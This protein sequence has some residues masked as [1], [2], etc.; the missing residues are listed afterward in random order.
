M[1][2]DTLKIILIIIEILLIIIGIVGAVL[3]VL[4][5]TWVVYAAM[6]IQHFFHDG[7]EY[8]WAILVGFG[9]VTLV[10]QVLDYLI[11]IWG[12][13]KLG[14]GKYGQWGTIIGALVGAFAYPPFGIIIGP[15]VGALLGELLSGKKINA[16]LKAGTGAFLG[17]VTG[18]VMKVGLGVIMGIWIIVK[19]F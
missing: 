11:P 17:F 16:A 7:A 18:V 5:G 8:H 1:D 15:F 14:A 3:P 2:G 10:V 6:L 13:K 19:M 4:P 12:S 9:L